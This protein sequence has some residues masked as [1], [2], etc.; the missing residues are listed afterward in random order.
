MQSAE[1]FST[2]EPEFSIK[3]DAISTLVDR[4]DFLPL[5]MIMSARFRRQLTED[6]PYVDPDWLVRIVSGARFDFSTISNDIL[7]P[8]SSRAFAVFCFRRED[9]S[10][11]NRNRLFQ[12]K[13]GGN[14]HRVFPNRSKFVDHMRLHT[15]DRPFSCPFAGCDKRFG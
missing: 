10:D 5:H 4:H 3:T 11:I 8:P 6:F 2:L 12:C 7:M 1:N 15:R 14:C 13:Y 9:G